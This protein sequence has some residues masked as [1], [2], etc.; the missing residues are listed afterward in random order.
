MDTNTRAQE[1]MKHFEQEVTTLIMTYVFNLS[2]YNPEEMKDWNQ[3]QV[4]EAA[5]NMYLTN[6]TFHRTVNVLVKTIMSKV[7]PMLH[8]E[9]EEC[10]R[11]VKEM[12]RDL[13]FARE[14]TI[15]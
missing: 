14:G 12:K 2:F 4:L 13:E 1:L 6:N 9:L 10:L 5:K 8:R 3:S 15:H 7:E 11:K